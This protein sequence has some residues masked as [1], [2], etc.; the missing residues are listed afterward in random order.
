[1]IGYLF[2]FVFFPADGAPL[3]PAGCSLCSGNFATV[4]ICVWLLTGAL[5][6]AALQVGARA[7]D[8]ADERS[9]RRH[10]SSLLR[11]RL[12]GQ[13]QGDRARRLPHV[14]VLVFDHDSSSW[15][16]TFFKTYRIVLCAV[17]EI[18]A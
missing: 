13:E 14:G 11:A 16:K 8:H 12:L 2:F 15:P 5:I 9:G 6:L 17:T 7:H 18:L 1:M 3:A 4:M 10:G